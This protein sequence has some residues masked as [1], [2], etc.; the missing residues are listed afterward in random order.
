[1]HDTRTVEDALALALERA[2]AAGEWGIVA[3]LATE[4]EARRLAAAGVTRI[5]D[6]KPRGTR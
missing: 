3:K 5:G 4:L 6:S 2:S 1:M